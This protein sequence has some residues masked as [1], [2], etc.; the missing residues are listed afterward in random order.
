MSKREASNIT[1]D[2]DINWHAGHYAAMELEFLDNED[3]LI[4]ETEHPLNH[5]LLRIDLLIV[6]KNKNI[7]IAN[8]LGAAFRGYNVME[9]KSEDDSLSIDTIFKVNAYA[10]L[11]KAYA[12]KVDGIK[13]DDV[14]VTLTKLGYPREAI[15]ALKSQGYIVEKKNHGI[16]MV[17]GNAILPTQ[18]IVIS[19]LREDLHFWITKLRKSITK[20]QLLQLLIKSKEL[21][22]KQIELYVGPLVSVLAD[23]NKKAMDKIREEEPD[24][25]N[26]FKEL[27]KKDLEKKWNDGINKGKTEDV[28]EMLKD[29]LSIDKI[30]QYTNLS[31]EQ[32]TAIGKQA[33]LL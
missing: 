8:E 31:I 13:I 18:I 12:D 19:Q 27:F 11:Y 20:E 25:G 9:Y 7:Q 6:K 10:L 3:D 33:A 32:I 29:N 21:T 28:I 15:K 14:T 24:M 22:T 17:T 30:A 16:Y 4:Y 23:V 5:E 1:N 2:N 26:Y